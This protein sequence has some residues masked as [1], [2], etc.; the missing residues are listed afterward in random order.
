MMPPRAR[1]C[2]VCGG[3]TKAL[4]FHWYDEGRGSWQYAHFHSRCFVEARRTD[5]LAQYLHIA[6]TVPTAN[7]NG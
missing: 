5:T 1:V 3:S 7:Q 4:P 6:C 2:V